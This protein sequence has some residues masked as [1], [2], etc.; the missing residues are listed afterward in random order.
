MKIKHLII[1]ICVVLLANITAPIHAQDATTDLLGRINELRASLGLPGYQLNSALSIA[2][3]NHAAWMSAS[4]QVSHTQPDGSTPRTRASAAGYTSS[5]VS[6]NIYMG[7]NATVSSAWGWWLNSPIHYRGITNA[8]YTEVGIGASSGASGTAFVLVFGNPAGYIPPAGVARAASADTSGGVP[9]APSF[10]VGVD[11]VG[12]IMHE[13][14]PGQTLGEIALIYG[15]T[16]DD[17]EYIRSIN[18]MTE[19][20]GRQ[21]EI[22][23]VMLVPPYEGTYTPV[24]GAADIIS[25]PPAPE[26]TSSLDQQRTEDQGILATAH[27]EEETASIA[28]PPQENNPEPSVTPI[29]SPTAAV[30]LLATSEELPDWLEQTVVPAQVTPF[31]P[32]QTTPIVMTM[33]PLSAEGTRVADGALVSAN[34]PGSITPQTAVIDTPEGETPILL[35]VAVL[36]QIALIGIAGFEFLRRRK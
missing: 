33:T 34:T 18:G 32:L 35:I 31:V 36:L 3:Q 12:N 14:Q 20:D 15:Y 13:I 25:T 27:P 24:P 21:L 28:I 30:A 4:G 23:S 22:G 19:A 10:I 6:E 16:W 7:S 9:A 8:T 5:A 11:N 17:L 2:A 1:I 29:P 26:A